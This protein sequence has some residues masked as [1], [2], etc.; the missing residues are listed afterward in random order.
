MKKK[1][2]QPRRLGIQDFKTVI[3]NVKNGVP[4]RARN[5]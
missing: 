4:G 5:F 1:K 3:K 2:F